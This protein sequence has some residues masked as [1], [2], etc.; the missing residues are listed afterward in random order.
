MSYLFAFY[1]FRMHTYMPYNYDMVFNFTQCEQTDREEMYL[2][3]CL[4]KSRSYQWIT[5]TYIQWKE[6][7]IRLS[8]K[9]VSLFAISYGQWGVF[10]GQTSHTACV[11]YFG[12]RISK[13]KLSH[14]FN[15]NVWNSSF[16]M[17]VPIDI[18]NGR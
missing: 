11:S 5:S 7:R 8:I 17:V 13:R 2:L 9:E 14:Y 12:Y 18:F 6:T 3:S 15:D 1:A 16:W 10:I 4:R